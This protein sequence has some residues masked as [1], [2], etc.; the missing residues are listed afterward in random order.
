M[1]KK[2]VVQDIFNNI[3][4]KY[5]LLNHLLSMNIDKGWRR[6]A[7][8]CI[9]EQEKGCLLDV[10]CG[11]GD[12]SIAAHRAGVKQVTGID[13]SENMV[14]IGKKKVGDL[15]LA[16]AIELKTGDCEH[17]EFATGMF[18]VVTVAFGVRNFEHLELGLQEMYRGESDYSRV[19]YA[20]AFS[21]E[22]VVP[23]LFLSY[24]SDDR[25]MDFRE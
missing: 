9:G 18:D 16:D 8:S 17:M 25:G 21:D 22:T 14:E 15:H 23:L 2:E 7:M 4:P 19:L 11:T 10:A 13:I 1:A 5:D 24:S 20:G 6:K 3:A 12:F